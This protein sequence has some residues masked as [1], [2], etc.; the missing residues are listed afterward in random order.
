MG[1]PA[2]QQTITG[3]VGQEHGIELETFIKIALVLQHI[4]NCYNFF[5]TLIF[6]VIICQ[7]FRELDP[8]IEVISIQIAH[9]FEGFNLISNQLVTLVVVYQAAILSHRVTNK[10]LFLI[11][12][13][14]TTVD[15]NLTRV[16]ALHLFVDSDRLKIK[17]I[18]GIITGNGLILLIRFRRFVGP[19][20]KLSKLLP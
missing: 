14:Q 15:S 9:F 11:K 20:V 17:T 8:D 12:L 7:N 18:T 6:A 1:E 16:E 13:S 5:K 19:Y 3:K 10:A 4:D 2:L